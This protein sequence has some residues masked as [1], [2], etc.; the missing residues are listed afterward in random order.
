MVNR[1]KASVLLSMASV[2]L[3]AGTGWAQS[4]AE[5]SFGI[6]EQG[7][8][9]AKE[10]KR[11]RATLALALLVKDER[12]M[13]LAETALSDPS[14]AVRAAAATTLGQIGLPA[15]IPKLT[16]AL[17][18][19]ETEVVFSAAGALHLLGDP[20][21]NNVYYAVLTGQRKTG[22]PLLESQLKMLTDPQAL[23]KIGF[24]AGMGFIP[25]G[26]VGTKVFKTVTRDKVSPVR[27]AAA[28]KLASDPDPRSARALADA[29]SDQEWLVRASAVSAIA[30]RGDPELLSAVIPLLDDE[31]DTV[32]FNAAAT[33]VKLS[34]KASAPN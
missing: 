32:R 11:E 21:A 8:G 27:A 30:K 13:G 22:E 7:L 34:A 2:W 9:D 6:L 25:F 14:S 4:P 31:E 24:E 28:Q 20:M 29:A 5:R 12:A 16:E 33:V 15:S 17:K 1:D 23:A 18:D 26:G 10:E 19:K 3:L